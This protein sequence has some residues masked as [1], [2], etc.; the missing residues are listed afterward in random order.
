MGSSRPLAKSSSISVRLRSADFTLEPARLTEAVVVTARRVE[1]TVQE[2]PIPVSV[3]DRQPDGRRRCVQCQP[4][5]GADSDRAVLLD[6]PP[7]LVDQHPRPRRAVRSDQRWHRAGRRPLHRRRVLRAAGRRRRS[8]SSTSSASRCCADRRARCSARTRRRARSTSRHGSRRSRAETDVELNYGNLGFVQA[9]ASVVGAARPTSVAGRL[10]FS[11]TTRDGMV[12]NVATGA[13]IERSQQPRRARA[14]AVCAVGSHRGDV[15]RSI[16]RGSVPRATR[17]SSPASRR[18][19][20]PANRQYAQIAAD[21]DYTP[22]SFNAFDRVTDI[23]T[24]LR[25][26]QDMGGA[27]LNIDWKLGRGRL[28][29]TSG[30]RYWNW[31]P[32]NDRDFIGLPVTTVSAAPSRQ[33]QWTQEVRYAGDVSPTTSNVVVG[34]FAFHQGIDSN[35]SFKQ[36]QGAAAARFLLAPSAAAATPGLLDGYGF[37]QYVD[38]PQ[39]E[40][41]GSSVS[42][43]RRSPIGCACCPA[44]ASTT[45]RRTS[46]S[47]SR[48]TAVCRRPIRRSIALAALDS[49]A[50]GL[51]D[52][53]RRHEPLGSADR[54][55]TGCARA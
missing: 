17:R 1:E 41:G 6:Q 31:N 34:A 55:R 35:P 28:T 30:W 50:A 47:I 15:G 46:T 48:S 27:S 51:H 33:R 38:V 19:C 22:P 24:P 3:V 10:S 39:P 53:R 45:T 7:Q 25:S 2:V 16:T 5:E 29:S 54:R 23:D 37:N 12:R 18:R 26:N 36:E 43:S 11:G 13:T 40:R 49:R 9:K 44:C 32:S 52:R 8:T 20:A 14:G 4:A 42:S 21:L